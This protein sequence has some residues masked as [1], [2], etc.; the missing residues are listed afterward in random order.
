M[1]TRTLETLAADLAAGRT[2]S[3]ALVDDCLA[4]IDDME[5]QGAVTFLHV[6]RTGAQSAADAMDRLRA[7][8]AITSRFAGIPISVKDLFDVQGQV[9]RA[10]S[11]ALH[12]PPADRD[13]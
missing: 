6:D 7:A 3:R 11:K 1:N 13:A 10:G 2:T 5:G 8:R 12:G 4:K 9:T